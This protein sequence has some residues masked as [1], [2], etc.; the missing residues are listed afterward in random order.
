MAISGLGKA[1][2]VV[3]VLSALA[4]VFVGLNVSL[5]P[6][7]ARVQ[8]RVGR[9]PPPPRAADAAAARAA[10]APRVAPAA[11]VAPRAA[12]ALA[13]C[14]NSSAHSAHTEYWGA[15]VSGA[16]EVGATAAAAACCRAC[17]AYEPTLDVQGGRPC[18]AF[19][20]HPVTGACWLKASSAAHLAAP[21]RGAR[22][23]WTSGALAG[24]FPPC[25]DCA[26]L[27]ATSF[28]GCVS[29]TRCNTSRECG[30]P[31]IDGYAHVDF[32]C[33]DGS[34]DA[35][36]Y[37][38][39]VAAGAR[40]AG[41]SEVGADYDGLGVRW[42]IGHKKANWSAC[43]D[44]CRAHRPAAAGLGGPF[45]GL[46][47]NVNARARRA[48]RNAAV[49]ARPRARRGRGRARA[50]ALSRA[51]RPP[52]SAVR[53]PRPQVWTWCGRRV[54]WEPDAH[55][56]SLGDCWLKF[57]ER[58]EAVEVN[59]RGPRGMPAGFLRRHRRELADGIPWVSGV[60]VAPG[61]AVTN[62]SWGP[63]AFW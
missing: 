43:E 32:K 38:A 1:R 42:G 35:R 34:A 29:K 23:P 54:C 62:G 9:Q 28:A 33:L 50:R 55:R 37:R 31:A 63:R 41:A 21:G 36:R 60:L 61:V 11:P 39:L 49:A 16:D 46:P 12:D 27:A 45:A 25:A 4:L 13:A 30:S 51:R 14:A 22:V 57:S 24:P 3:G 56:H 52:P 58:P 7:R 6:F 20:W 40:L 2:L 44:A 26:P 15:V 59:M 17:A 5:D 48:R 10:V 18:N 8:R 53:H 19:V 47:C